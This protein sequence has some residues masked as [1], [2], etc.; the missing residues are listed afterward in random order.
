MEQVLPFAVLLGSI[1]A[2]VTLSR[3][4]S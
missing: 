4:R 2:F 3:G 1:A